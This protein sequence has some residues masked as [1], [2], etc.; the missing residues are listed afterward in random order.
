MI[1]EVQGRHKPNTVL[2]NA[3]SSQGIGLHGIPS[4]I[5]E[6]QNRQ[7]TIIRFKRK[8]GSDGVLFLSASTVGSSF[9]ICFGVQSSR[10]RV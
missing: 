4:H 2:E 10:L 1:N 9:S 3:A 5:H 7:N 8:R 6:G